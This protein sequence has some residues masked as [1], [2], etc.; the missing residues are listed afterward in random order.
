MLFRS[1]AL[2]LGVMAAGGRDR[3]AKLAQRHGALG[4]H[5][6]GGAAHEVDAEV[7]ALGHERADRAEHQNGRQDRGEGREPHEVD[8]ELA[9]QDADALDAYA[10]S[11]RSAAQ[12]ADGSL[13][14]VQLRS[15]PLAVRSRVVRQWLTDF[16]VAADALGFDQIRELLRLVTE[17]NLRGPVRLAGGVEVQTASGRLRA[18]RRNDG[19]N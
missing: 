9:R 14:L 12:A 4:A 18:S 1:E 10:V 8:M 5:L 16:G 19:S 6:D 11:V 13:E 3:G 17:P 7:Q 2:D 15:A